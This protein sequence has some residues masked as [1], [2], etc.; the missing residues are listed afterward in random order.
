MKWLYNLINYFR[1]KPVK[2]PTRTKPIRRIT[3]NVPR[4]EYLTRIESVLNQPNA[5]N[6]L[7]NAP[8]QD[9]ELIKRR[10]ADGTI[11]QSELNTKI[12]Y[13]SLRNSTEVKQFNKL[14]WNDPEFKQIWDTYDTKFKIA[15]YKNLLAKSITPAGMKNSIIKQSQSSKIPVNPLSAKMDFKIVQGIKFNAAETEA[16]NSA[17]GN[18]WKDMLVGYWK[19]SNKT[20]KV[21]VLGKAEV[22]SQVKRT[23]FTKNKQTYHKFQID[24]ALRNAGMV[25]KE[26]T[27]RVVTK[28]DA[29]TVYK[30]P[31][32][33]VA[34]A[35]SATNEVFIVWE[36]FI[37]RNKNISTSSGYKN[38]SINKD[39]FSNLIY[40]ELAHIKDPAITRSY[41]S[42]DA[43]RRNAQ[44]WKSLTIKNTEDAQK[45]LTK[46]APDNWYKNYFFHVHE[47]VANFAPVLSV[48][49]NNTKNIVKIH[50]KQKTTAALNE[51]T[52]WLATGTKVDYVF[53][54]PLSEK[55]LGF[56]EWYNMPKF[57]A[58]LPI[59]QREPLLKNLANWYF[60]KNPGKQPINIFLNDYKYFSP[61]GYKK[62]SYKIARQIDALKQQVRQTRTLTPESIMEFKVIDE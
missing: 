42:H 43:Y 7:K 23:K 25:P 37:P 28:H 30:V 35:N 27:I 9:I 6:W 1:G 11:T 17:V 41:K 57:V 16:I 49:V 31:Q 58:D 33:Y 38:L 52:E 59:V 53:K 13:W 14:I 40:H 62:M 36:K 12:Y 8:K 51:I 45:L 60:P 5:Q 18:I 55:I 56:S 26:V 34:W 61:D 47:M 29:V 2:V 32:G 44:S 48:M 24:P 19:V 3:P 46:S 20:Y 50:G 22:W 21:T 39:E 54:N 15:V 4:T 10:V